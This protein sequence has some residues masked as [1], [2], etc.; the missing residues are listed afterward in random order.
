MKKLLGALI[1]IISISIYFLFYRKNNQF[2][3]NI[4]QKAKWIGGKDGGNWY[5]ISE[6]FPENA[7]R[8]KVYNDKSGELEA[9]AIFKLNPD[10]YSKK[11]DSILLLNKITGYDGMHIFLDFVQNGKQCHLMPITN[12]RDSL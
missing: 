11:I 10:C 1:V 4:E 2:P 6:V 12:K 7:F 8:I 3:A 5:Y 9:D